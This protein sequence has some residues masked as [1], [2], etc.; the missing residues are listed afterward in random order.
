MLHRP[1]RTSPPAAARRL[2]TAALALAAAFAWIG[3]LTLDGVE[4]R[5]LGEAA[6]ASLAPAGLDAATTRPARLHLLPTPRLELREVTLTGAGGRIVARLPEVAARLD[7]TALAIGRIA[8]AELVLDRPFLDI[9]GTGAGEEAIT[10]LARRVA[11]PAP[12]IR[13]REGAARWRRDEGPEERA[14]SIAFDLRWRA[15][16]DPATLEGTA[17]WRGAQVRSTVWLGRPGGLRE[18]RESPIELSLSAP[19][20]RLAFEGV[21]GGDRTASASG[22]LSASTAS[23][24]AL[25]E[26][27]RLQWPLPSGGDAATLRAQLTSR[28]R[29]VSLSDVELTLGANA[30]EGS[31]SLRREGDRPSLA[32]TLAS[33]EF[34]ADDWL[35]PL[36]RLLSPGDLWSEAPLPAPPV[37]DLDLDL[38]ISAAR[39]RLG[40]LAFD[41]TALSLQLKRG[42]LEVSLGE[43]SGYKGEFRGRLVVAPGRG[44]VETRG[45]LQWSAIDAA[46][47]LGALAARNRLSGQSTG[48]LTFES[49]G[50]SMQEWAAHLDGRGQITLRGG[51]ITRLDLE[52]TLR[53]PDRRAPASLL[54]GQTGRTA[55]DTLQ[56][57]LRVQRGQAMIEDGAMRGP[58]ATAVFRGLVDLPARALSL[59]VEA[60]QTGIPGQRF[61]FY[62]A[63]PWAAPRILPDAEQGRGPPGWQ[64]R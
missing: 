64:A 2:T 43:A 5:R 41:E 22:R 13:V 61:A 29:T 59:H 46:A 19:Q 23:L 37:G 52:Q 18:G 58:G 31:L 20:L 34:R 48:Q 44:R 35:A 24:A 42:R 39:A 45:A 38:R 27:L 15:A 40:R 36:P 11:P 32:G 25:A 57:G 56:T 7:W 30:F 10:A 55:F 14:R 50:A 16:D 54:K 8:P 63:G 4:A 9:D 49:A 53:R 28:G 6:L 21:T 62:L 26:L 60:S 3:L 17:D 1:D 33:D 47:F 51:E 12:R